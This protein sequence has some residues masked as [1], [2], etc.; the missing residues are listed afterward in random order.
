VRPYPGPGGKLQIS[1]GGGQWPHWSPVKH[2]LFYRD[3]E[4]RVM[5]ATY[6]E[7]SAVFRAEKPRPWSNRVFPSNLI[8][9]MQRG[10]F[11]VHPDGDRLA[12]F[13]PPDA[14]PGA[15]SVVLVLGFLDEL[16]RTEGP[17]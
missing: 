13:V 5:V 10:P 16:R 1:S 4:H 8:R 11:A 3:D 12:L 14:R 15:G 9:P 17:R 2:E 7:S 6:A